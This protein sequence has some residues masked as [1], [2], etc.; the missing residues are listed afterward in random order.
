MQRGVWSQVMM[1][2]SSLEDLFGTRERAIYPE[3]AKAV[4]PLHLFYRVKLVEFH[5]IPVEPHP[6]DS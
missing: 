4:F 1:H 6:L 2:R 5:H 3:P